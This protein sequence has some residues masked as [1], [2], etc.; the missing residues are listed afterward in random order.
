MSQVARSN[1]TH[2]PMDVEVEQYIG[3]RRELAMERS[4]T[5]RNLQ[6]SVNENAPQASVMIK[7]KDD[8]TLLRQLEMFHFILYPKSTKFTWASL[9]SE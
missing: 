7:A 6:A 8:A 9:A 1:N 2:T 3:R 5:N 4:S